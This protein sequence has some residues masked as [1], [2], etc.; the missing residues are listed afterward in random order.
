MAFSKINFW[1]GVVMMFSLFTIGITSVGTS[2]SS[3]LSLTDESQ[4]YIDLM[5]GQS[6]EDGTGTLSDK[7]ADESK[8][9]SYISSDNETS[10][11]V[12]TDNVGVLFYFKK[13]GTAF[14][15]T[16]K[17]SLN[18]PSTMLLG[19]GLPVENFRVYLNIFVY[20]AS[21]GITMAIVRS[22]LK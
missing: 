7:A 8:K 21:L 12:G 9:T 19:L 16:I 20:L 22:I 11:V 5:D 10:S 13:I 6:A 17:I 14:E 18:A 1:V 3:E 15:N 4:D 2:F